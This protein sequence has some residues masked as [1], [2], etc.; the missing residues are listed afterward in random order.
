MFSITIFS[1][2]SFDLN[3]LDSSDYIVN[4]FSGL[5][6]IAVVFFNLYIEFRPPALGIHHVFRV[7]LSYLALPYEGKMQ[8]L[9]A[10]QNR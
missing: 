5:F 8:S 6:C 2:F 4:N 1:F 3:S 9:S 10:H 7:A